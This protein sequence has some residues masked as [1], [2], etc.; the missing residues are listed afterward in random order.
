MLVVKAAGQKNSISF[1]ALHRI[2]AGLDHRL[3]IDQVLTQ[4]AVA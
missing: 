3:P 2:P 4:M 1:I